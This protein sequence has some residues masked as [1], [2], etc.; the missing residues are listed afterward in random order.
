MPRL[1]RLNE[2]RVAMQLAM[3]D[4]QA[5]TAMARAAISGPL[6][7]ISAPTTAA[8]TALGNVMAARALKQQKEFFSWKCMDKVGG[9]QEG[10]ERK[11][12]LTDMRLLDDQTVEG[13]PATAYEFFVRDGDKLQ[14]PV[15][16]LVTKDS[17]LPLRMEMT[18][19]Q[20]RGSMHMDYSYDNIADIEM[21][22]CMAC[23]Q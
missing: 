2:Q 23:G 18:D 8:A 13:K 6:G 20:G 3:L 12:L 22:A 10:A 17:G 4:Q 7:W 14:G 11:N 1:L 19:P 15:R 5:A 21:P 9:G 16:L